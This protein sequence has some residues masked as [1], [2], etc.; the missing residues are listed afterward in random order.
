[1]DW[2]HVH[3]LLSVIHSA[4]AAGPKFQRYAAAADA[5]LEAHWADHSQ[6]QANINEVEDASEGE[7]DPDVDVPPPNSRRL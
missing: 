1:M 3:N 2:Q 5:E 7:P 6:R 4:S